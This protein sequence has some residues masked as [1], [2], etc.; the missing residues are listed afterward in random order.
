MHRI[1]LVKLHFI[2]KKKKEEEEASKAIC[3]AMCVCSQSI[4]NTKTCDRD[5]EQI[6]E[7]DNLVNAS[8]SSYLNHVVLVKKKLH[9]IT[10]PHFLGNNGK[11]IKHILPFRDWD[12]I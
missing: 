3:K 1:Q 2:K 6:K 4:Q 8:Y 10:F 7:H 5:F 11:G 12:L 9:S